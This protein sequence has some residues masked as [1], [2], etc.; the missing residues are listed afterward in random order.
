MID[1]TIIMKLLCVALV[2]AF[3]LPVGTFVFPFL[4]S[5]LSG[6]QF[7]ALEAVVSASLGFGIFAMFG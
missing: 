7:Q 4:S 6:T 3:M 1:R 2:A 5:A